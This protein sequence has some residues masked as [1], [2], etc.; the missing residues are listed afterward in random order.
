MVT[1]KGKEGQ[2]TN[3]YL[4]STVC[5]ILPVYFYLIYFSD[6]LYVIFKNCIHLQAN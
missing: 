1:S 4:G 6:K 2:E 3:L 5:S